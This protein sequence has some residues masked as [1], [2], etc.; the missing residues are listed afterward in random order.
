MKKLL[1][2]T[3][4]IMNP[5]N[6]NDLLRMIDS[7]DNS[8]EKYRHI[9]LIQSDYSAFVEQVE[10]LRT[11][12][13]VIHSETIVSLSKARNIIYNHA[14]D[15]D[16]LSDVEL[17]A[18]PDDDCWY[19]GDNLNKIYSMFVED[20]ALDL[21]VCRSSESAEEITAQDKPRDISVKELINT[22]NSNTIFARVTAID[23]DDFFDEALGIGSKNNGGE[24]VDF[25][26]RCFVKARKAFYLDKSIVWHR[27]QDMA[28]KPVYF[29]GGF[30]ALKKNALKHPMFAFYCFRKALVGVYYMLKYGMSPKMFLSA[31]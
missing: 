28:E 30:K 19:P 31:S 14:K 22:C 10:Y 15:N 4:C 2:M 27:D 18:F 11:K 25:A 9:I 17:I 8:D 3:T 21:F 5:D 1:M 13:I 7:Y 23:F 6:V 12:A 24:D 16:L 26:M 20:S 29:R